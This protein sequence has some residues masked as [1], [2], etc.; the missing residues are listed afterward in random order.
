MA[1]RVVYAAPP[2]SMPDNDLS[3]EA[4]ELGHAN[5]EVALRC[6]AIASYHSGPP[7]A[8]SQSLEMREDRSVRPLG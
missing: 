4:A 8:T 5:A 2:S 3:I 1:W 6:R 7:L